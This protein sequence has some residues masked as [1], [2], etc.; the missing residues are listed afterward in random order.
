MVGRLSLGR[1]D[2]LRCPQRMQ[3]REM[4]KKTNKPKP[5]KK[6]TRQ[7][8]VYPDETFI[9]PFDLGN[10]ITAA[11]PLIAA[12]CIDQPR[13]SQSPCLTLL[14]NALLRPNSEPPAPYGNL[15]LMCI[16]LGTANSFL[17]PERVPGTQALS[18]FPDIGCILSHGFR[19]ERS[20]VK[21]RNPQSN[22]HFCTKFSSEYGSKCMKICDFI[23]SGI[24]T[25]LGL[26]PWK[27]S[28][29]SMRKRKCKMFHF[30]ISD[31]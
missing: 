10:V 30:H 16:T 17:L 12:R 25:H 7:H 6:N 11:C 9:C 18:S 13:S 22:H 1:W 24:F 4:K 26:F 15:T 23:A 31:K 8:N 21:S 14:S 20:S 19:M 3:K 29:F 2:P 27:F 28:T 5:K